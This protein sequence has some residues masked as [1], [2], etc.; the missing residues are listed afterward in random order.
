MGWQNIQAPFRGKEFLLRME[1]VCIPDVSSTLMI[2]VHHLFQPGTPD[3]VLHN[4]PT[5]VLKY[6]VSWQ[7][8]I[9][10]H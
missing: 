7:V 6:D 5:L 4:I 3:T 1:A 10:C 2:T 9:G 8:L